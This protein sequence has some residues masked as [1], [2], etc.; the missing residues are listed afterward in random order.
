MWKKKEK[1]RKGYI[2]KKSL[3]FFTRNRKGNGS[4]GMWF[5]FVSKFQSKINYSW[6][7]FYLFMQKKKKK[8]DL[9]MCVWDIVFTLSFFFFC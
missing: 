6:N 5:H 4:I 8:K 3:F 7:R 2:K 9:K 1:K